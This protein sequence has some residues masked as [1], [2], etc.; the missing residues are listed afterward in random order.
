MILMGMFINTWIYYLIMNE[1]TII[2]KKVDSRNRIVL[3]LKSENNSIFVANIGTLL[4]LGKSEKELEN[5]LEDLKKIQKTK[6]K[7]AIES[8]FNLIEEAELSNMT[9]KEIQDKNVSIIKN[10][11]GDI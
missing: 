9:K 5:L 4:I 11:I 10:R 1:G 3:P 8:W 2:E 7:E 6:E